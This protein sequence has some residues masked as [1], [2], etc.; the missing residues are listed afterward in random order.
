MT[1][2]WP[3]TQAVLKTANPTAVS[4]GNGS[5]DCYLGTHPAYQPEARAI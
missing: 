2:Y 5:A 1:R 4:C 3:C